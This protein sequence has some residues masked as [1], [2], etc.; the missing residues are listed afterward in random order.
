MSGVLHPVVAVHDLAHLDPLDRLHTLIGGDNF[1]PRLREEPIT[2]DMHDPIY[3]YSC[4]IRAAQ[5]ARDVVVHQARAGTPGGAAQWHWR[6]TV[7]SD[8]RRI[9]HQTARSGDGLPLA[10]LPKCADRDAF[11]GGLCHR[12]DVLYRQARRRA[13]PRF[14]EAAWVARQVGPPGGN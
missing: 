11:A 3:G 5:H 14:V 2:F 9:P 4:G 7:E 6:T 10:R 12:H 8:S 13:G 1:D